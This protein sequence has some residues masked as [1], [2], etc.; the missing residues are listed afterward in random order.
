MQHS[1]NFENMAPV[2]ARVNATFVGLRLYVVYCAR[3]SRAADIKSSELTQQRFR[4]T[5]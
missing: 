4:R 1:N 5:P 2:A 3:L